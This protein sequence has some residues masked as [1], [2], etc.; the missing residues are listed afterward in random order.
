MPRAQDASKIVGAARRKAQ[1][2]M[3]HAEAAGIGDRRHLD[4]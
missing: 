1:A 3:R 4:L 2:V